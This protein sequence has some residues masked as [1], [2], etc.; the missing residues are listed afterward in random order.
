MKTVWRR[1]EKE[2]FYNCLKNYPN[3]LEH[4][5]YM[6]LDSWYDYSITPNPCEESKMFKVYYDEEYYIKC[7]VSDSKQ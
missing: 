1:V 2:V 6:D 4:D 7:A 3:K 5:F